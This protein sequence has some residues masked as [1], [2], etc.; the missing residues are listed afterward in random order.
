M[1]PVPPA[2]TSSSISQSGI[3]SILSTL[4]DE[5][6]QE[7]AC[8]MS[9]IQPSQE[10]V[11]SSGQAPPT[12]GETV[13]DVKPLVG[14]RE[15]K[16]S[17]DERL[18]A[19]QTNIRNQLPNKLTTPTDHTL[20]PNILTT[21]T[22]HTHSEQYN[23]EYE[24]GRPREVGGAAGYHSGRGVQG[25]DQVA[26]SA[27]RSTSGH[28]SYTSYHDNVPPE[29]QYLPEYPR[30]SYNE[31]PSHGGPSHGGPSHSGPSHGGPSHDGPS[32][33]GRHYDQYYEPDEQHYWG[34]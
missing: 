5:K 32:H 9:T 4:S 24:Q 18:L 2:G 21:P 19:I 11:A 10:G 25:S 14:Q 7:L 34:Q 23:K 17:L 12:G 27:V 33:S 26:Y 28:Y 1:K 31:E 6:L 16:Q 8:A 20:S 29:R 30:D 3:Q 13:S 15:S 22:D